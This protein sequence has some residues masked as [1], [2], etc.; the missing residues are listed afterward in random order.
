MH[1]HYPH[2]PHPET[3]P[4]PSWLLSQ[5]QK[6]TAIHV[7]NSSSDKGSC[8]NFLFR[9]MGSYFNN[10]KLAYLDRKEK[11]HDKTS[12]D[13][14]NMLQNFE[15]SDD[16]KFRT[17]SDVPV[18]ELKNLDIERGPAETL[19]ISTNKDDEGRLINKAIDNDPTLAPISDSAK[20]TRLTRKMQYLQYLFISIAWIILPAFRLFMLCPECIWCDVT[21]NLNNKGY[22]NI[23]TFSCR[24]SIDKQVFF[25]WIWIPNKERISS[26]CVF[27]HVISILIPKWLREQFYYGGWG[28]SAKE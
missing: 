7:M 15:T 13:I 25:L 1:E 11:S 2:L 17:L 14:H 6:Q 10:I 18:S 4:M 23:I 9:T 21:S 20:K 5:E 12:D 28:S 27:Q 26:R 24:R 22:N 16:I 3:A 19:T 8:R